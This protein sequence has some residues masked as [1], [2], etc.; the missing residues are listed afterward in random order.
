MKRLARRTLLRGAGGVALSLPMLDA[1]LPRRASAATPPRRLLIVFT[2]NGQLADYW[3]PAGVGASFR[4]GS[5]LTPFAPYQND[6]V[7]LSGVSYLPVGVLDQATADH[8]IKRNGHMVGQ[9]CMLTG[10]DVVE[11]P[12]GG[13]F[14]LSP[15]G[16]SV[17]RELAKY[18]VGKTPLPTMHMDLWPDARLSGTLGPAAYYMSWN[19]PMRPQIGEHRLDRLTSMIFSSGAMLDPK[20]QEDLRLRRKSVLDAALAEYGAM[21]A[22]LGAADRRRLDQ[23]AESVRTLERSIDAIF[24]PSACVDP[25]VAVPA[26]GPRGEVRQLVN[27]IPAISEAQFDL[28]TSALACDVTRVMTFQWG[29]SNWDHSFPWLGINKQFHDITHEDPGDVV[30]RCLRWRSEQLAKLIGK[31][32]NTPEGDGSLLDSTLVVWLTDVNQGWLH[33]R[34][35]MPIAL[36]GKAGGALRTGRHVVAPANTS[37]N[38]LLVWILNVMGVPTN[39]FGDPR[40]VKGPLP[41]LS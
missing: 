24:S 9:C 1:M 35:N 34:D 16:I 26:Y 39:T 22:R 32:K 11:Y 12:G 36:F 19:G 4:L 8:P 41:D 14:N 5:L 15:N 40:Y 18:M 2:P 3:K 10:R 17:D 27:Q 33:Y 13:Q 38:D 37:N 20:A 31:L 6:M 30:L 25:K 28:I 29:E 23:H 7:M 21:S